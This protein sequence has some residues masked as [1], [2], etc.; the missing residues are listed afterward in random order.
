M[1]LVYLDKDYT[2][3]GIYNDIGA[4]GVSYTISVNITLTKGW[5]FM[6]QKYT[7][8]TSASMTS[9]QTLPSG[10]KWVIEKK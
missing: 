7:S 3:T 8:G 10:Y 5:N 9:S 1:F 2:A 4:E 6:I